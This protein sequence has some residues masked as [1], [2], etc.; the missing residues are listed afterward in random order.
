MQSNHF[1]MYVK[2]ATACRTSCL[3]LLILLTLTAATLLAPTTASA[4]LNPKLGRFM[5]R[6]PLNQ[7]QT[8]GGYQDGLSLYQYVKSSPIIN[9]DSSGKQIPGEYP[10]PGR[11]PDFGGPNGPRL[12]KNGSYAY[13]L[14]QLKSLCNDKCLGECPESCTKEKCLQEA[15][16]IARAYSNTVASKRADDWLFD[17]WITDRRGGKLCYQWRSTIYRS[18]N[19][20]SLNNGGYSCFKFAAAAS[21][22]PY[23]TYHNWVNVTVSDEAKPNGGCTKRLDPWSGKGNPSI[24]D[25]SNHGYRCTAIGHPKGPPYWGWGGDYYENGRRYPSWTVPY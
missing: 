18:L 17:G 20:D 7:D 4:M 14:G 10:F 9:H 11:L 3:P 16:S 25:D 5:Q 24:Y 19:I 21:A 1:L 2:T 12:P 23:T 22:S 15:E 13:L 6:D 8:G